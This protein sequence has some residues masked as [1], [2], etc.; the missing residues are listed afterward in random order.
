MVFE[1]ISWNKLE[2][3]LEKSAYLQLI[4]TIIPLKSKKLESNLSHMC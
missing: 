4:K 3:R 1:E 2:N